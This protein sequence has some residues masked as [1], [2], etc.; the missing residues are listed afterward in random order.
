VRI[1]WISQLFDRKML[2]VRMLIVFACGL[3]Y[4]AQLR[5]PAAPLRPADWGLA[6]AA[7]AA[8]AGGSRWPLATVLVQA[9]LLG[10]AGLVGAT[11]LVPI[12]VAASVAIFELAIHRTGWPLLVGWGVLASVYATRVVSS[13]P[14]DLVPMLY[15]VTVLIGLPLLLGAYL[16]SVRQVARQAEWRVAEEQR[17]RLSESALVRVN[18]RTAIARELHDLVAQHIASMVLRVGVARHVLPTTDPK[19]REVLDDIHAGGTATLADLRRLVALLREP[20]DGPHEQ[21]LVDP[22]ELPNALAEV[23]ERSRKVGLRVDTSVDPQITGVD[24]VRGLAVLRLTQEGLTNVAKHAGAAAQASVSV[25]INDEGAVSVEIRDDGGD[26]RAEAARYG[27]GQG[28]VGMRERVQLLGGKLEVAAVN[29]GWRLAATLPAQVQL[30][31]SR[32]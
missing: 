2:P 8:S 19:V 29:G 9:T 5:D 14:A 28:L 27:L 12:K 18:E 16:R 32:P 25:R 17:R 21:P 1:E 10:T 30:T 13:M 22:S 23:V 11:M 4:L 26:G 20:A 15:R 7:V 31:E 24:A 6:I 3:G